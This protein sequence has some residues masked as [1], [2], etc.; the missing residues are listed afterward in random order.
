MDLGLKGKSVL[1]AAA[2]KG[3]GRAVATEFAREGARLV[4]CSREE[5]AIKKT[6]EEIAKETKAEVHPLAA[7]LS[8]K[9]G[10]QAFVDAAVQ[11]HGGI[12]VL[13]VNAGGP[14]PGRFDDLDDAAW[15]KAVELT[16]F[17][18][19]RTTRLALP[20]LRRS[21][22]NIVYMTSTSVRQ[23]TQY[24]N[25]ILSNAIRAAVQGMMKT[26]SADLAKDGIRVNAVQ[27]G[28]I[29]TDRLL[30]LDKIT[31]EKTGKSMEEVRKGWEQNAIPIGRYGEP[32]EFANAVV[33]LASARASYVTGVS[34]QVDGGM[35]MSMF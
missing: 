9:E 18:A 7:D 14:P 3:L 16:L 32:A 21:K 11:R 28:R 29:A 12:D 22:G 27:P 1:V 23:P 24:L 5:A 31:A 19:V 10:C 15:Q 34:L 33:F 30:Q 13:V 2:S 35:L 20:H 17:S 8:T 4:V 26:L 25:L 6:A